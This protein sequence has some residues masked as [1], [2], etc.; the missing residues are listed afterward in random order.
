MS[1]L[2]QTRNARVFNISWDSLK[3]DHSG[4]LGNRAHIL[5]TDELKLNFFTLDRR[6]PLYRRGGERYFQFFGPI[7][8]ETLFCSGAAATLLELKRV[9]AWENLYQ[10]YLKT[11]IGSVSQHCLDVMIER[12]CNTFY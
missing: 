1:Y 8:E 5:F 9:I 6:I 4:C 2:A 11:L 3:F 10:S 7:V 12:G